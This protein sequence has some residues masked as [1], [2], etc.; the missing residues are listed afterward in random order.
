MKDEI[1]NLS[2]RE[3]DAAV[4]REV[5]KWRLMKKTASGI[6]WY[7]SED[8][9][10]YHIGFSRSL[11]PAWHPSEQMEAAWQV[12]EAAVNKITETV[13]VSTHIVYPGS[14]DTAVCTASIDAFIGENIA[15]AD[16]DTLQDALCRCS[17]RACRAL[18]V[19][20]R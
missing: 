13:T 9:D 3:L 5:M 1:D 7:E 11:G 20:P 10:V 4:A 18:T 12:M 6:L 14:G 8:G 15:C 17:I 19:N 2:G 16:G